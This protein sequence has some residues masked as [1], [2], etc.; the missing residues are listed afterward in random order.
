M[1]A[2]KDS[3]AQSHLEEDEWKLSS[4][5]GGFVSVTVGKDNSSSDVIQRHIHEFW[6]RKD[7]FELA[8]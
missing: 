2:G 8:L 7:I 3:S 4:L 5:S 1:S 6:S